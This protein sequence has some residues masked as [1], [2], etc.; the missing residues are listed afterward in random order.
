MPF[1]SNAPAVFQA[2]V[3]DVLRDFLNHSVFVYLEDILIVSQNLEE[4]I[5]RSSQGPGS[6]RVVTTQLME[7]APEILG[8]RQFL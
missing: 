1:G 8:L 7:A 6:H 2:L 3:N 5:A 4:H